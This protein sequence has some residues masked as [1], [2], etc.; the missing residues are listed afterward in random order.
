[1]ENVTI[2]ISFFQAKAFVLLLVASYSAYE[3]HNN[4]RKAETEESRKLNIG[5]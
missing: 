1:M 2:I 5:K 4:A 3:A